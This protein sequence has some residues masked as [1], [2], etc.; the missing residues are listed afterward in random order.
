[1][2]A[3][4]CQTPVFSEG[5]LVFDWNPAAASHADLTRPPLTI[6]DETL[7]DGL[8]SASVLTPSIDAK[9]ELLHHMEAVGIEFVNLGMPSSSPLM[10]QTCLLLARE[11]GSA[12]LRIHPVCAARTRSSDIAAIADVA[13]QT[14]VA[15]EAYTFLGTSPLRSLV[16]DWDLA[17]LTR[18][19]STA[20]ETAQQAGLPVTFVTEDTTRSRPELLAHL[21]RVAVDHGAQRFCLCDTVGSADP[22][23]VRALLTFVNTWIAEAHLAGRIAI[24]WHG[25]NDRGLALANALMAARCGATRLHV[26]ALGL[27]ERVGNVATEQLIGNLALMSRENP[28][29]LAELPAYCQ[30][31]ARHLGVAIAPQQPLVGADA[32]RTA[33]GTHAS[34]IRKA[35]RMGR[36]W[37]ADRMYSSIVA[38]DLQRTQTIAVG[39]CSGA[40]NAAEALRTLGIEPSEA[41]VQAL[42]HIAQTSDHVL[43]DDEI[44]ALYRE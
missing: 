5:D 28:Y 39:P 41:H 34:A 23:G 24:D 17:T 16:E 25:H 7:R 19:T 2:A 30:A 44:R 10:R 38:S 26:T 40:S 37:L 6:L 4:S 36:A 20:L 1:M 22:E 43:S 35:N 8:Q 42:L 27:G 12:K 13:E 33:T 32:F 29:S 18:N 31:V 15:L 11:I 9:I 3:S 14:G 21:F